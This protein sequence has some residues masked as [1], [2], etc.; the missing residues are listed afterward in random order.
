MAE[1]FE[2]I[3]QARLEYRDLSDPKADPRTIL[4]NEERRD[5]TLR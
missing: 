2:Y 1:D 4:V 5:L 3:S